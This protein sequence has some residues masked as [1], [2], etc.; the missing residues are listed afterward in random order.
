MDI[1]AK[2]EQ[3]S[4]ALV[5]ANA[6]RVTNAA[7]LRAV[8]SHGYSDGLDYVAELLRHAD[9]DGPAGSLQI[10]KLLRAISRMDLER[11]HEDCRTALIFDLRRPLRRLSERQRHG[12]AFALND[13]AART[14][15][16]A[17]RR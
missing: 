1:T 6:V 16:R 10:G 3:A 2:R 8:K 11:A 9:L 12:L 14:R 17:R 7:T 13:R 15:Q 4:R 5:I